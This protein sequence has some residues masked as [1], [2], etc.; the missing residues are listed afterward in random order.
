MQGPRLSQRWLWGVI[1]SW[2]YRRV[3]WWMVCFHRNTRN[4]IPENTSSS[5]LTEPQAS[6]LLK[7]RARRLKL[8]G[9]MPAKTRSFIRQFYDVFSCCTR[10]HWRV[11]TGIRA[12]Y[13][14]SAWY[15]NTPSFIKQSNGGPLHV[16]EMLQWTNNITLAGCS[17]AEQSHT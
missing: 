11:L 7:K 17:S 2:I 12:G 10:K 6:S 8:N 3:L 4:Y 15:T 1:T 9:F 5:V 14:H 13:H 16:P